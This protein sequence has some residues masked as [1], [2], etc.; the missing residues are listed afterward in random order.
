MPF[1]SS[2]FFPMPLYEGITVSRVSKPE[3]IGGAVERR[4]RPEELTYDG[5]LTL[6]AVDQ[7]ARRL[8][9]AGGDPI[10]LGDRYELL[11]RVLRVLSSEFDGV[12]A[13]VDI[14][15]ELLIL[16]QLIV[17]AGGE[18]VLDDT[19]LI[20]AA[21][22]GGL[23]G[24]AWETNDR[25]TSFSS[26]SVSRLRLDGVFVRLRLDAGNKDSS[27]SLA[28]VAG[29]IEEVERIGQG[30]PVFLAPLSVRRA[31]NGYEPV[32]ETEEL[33]K[34]VGVAS[35]LGNT[36]TRTWL[37]LPPVEEFA[38]V[39]RATTLPVL[40]Q[41]GEADADVP[42]MLAAFAAGLK[43]GGNVRGTLA[44]ASVLF[45]PGGDDP[46]V[47]ARAIELVVHDGADAPSA[48]AQAAEARGNDGE[49][50]RKLF[51]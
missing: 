45:P 35:A 10:A 28:S 30:L 1:H 44:G 26:D 16:D 12:V 25:F 6:L 51:P 29:A 27:D 47:V 41:G 3:L 36:S 20:A 7:P 39:T 15:E 48:W 31:A 17:N 42:A 2:D 33:V 11:G 34:I 23:A 5:K 40:M 24:S 18:S 37:V 9:A 19:L 46:V 14:M 49:W 21:N 38:W 43:A 32:L 50:L 8:T 4:V 13:T 22:P